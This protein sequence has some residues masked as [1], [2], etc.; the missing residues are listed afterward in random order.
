M[1]EQRTSVLNAIKKHA[2]INLEI[3]ED[4]GKHNNM[5]IQPI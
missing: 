2:Y 5:K 1:S 3:A 4:K